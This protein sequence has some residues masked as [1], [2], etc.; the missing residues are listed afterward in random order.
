MSGIYRTMMMKFCEL[1][2][3]IDYRLD[4][5]F[6]LGKKIHYSNDNGSN[7]TEID[8]EETNGSRHAVSYI[9]VVSANAKYFQHRAPSSEQEKSQQRYRTSSVDSTTEA[10][11]GA[12]L[13]RSNDS[14]A[15]RRDAA[16]LRKNKGVYI[17]VV[18]EN[19]V[20]YQGGGMKT[21]EILEAVAAVSK[22]L[23]ASLFQVNEASGV[24]KQVA[25]DRAST[26]YVDGACTWSLRY[27]QTR[28]RD[29]QRGSQLMVRKIGVHGWDGTEAGYGEFESQERLA[30]LFAP[31]GT[32][33][34]IHVRH[35]VENNSIEESAGSDLFPSPKTSSGEGGGGKLVNSSYAI[36]TFA[37]R[38]EAESV[39][40]APYPGVFAGDIRL[41][42]SPFD[43]KKAR[44]ST[45][46]PFPLHFSVQSAIDDRSILR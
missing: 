32:I 23:R 19:V 16:Q 22:E 45:A 28:H 12:E 39:L 14:N 38:A 36:V 42:I 6:I 3:D 15:K 35:R 17:S 46:T 1:D 20:A 34:R 43:R 24:Y 21:T 11:D 10:F 18:D 37:T 9:R 31:F 30:D 33:V 7:R 40:K 27:V 29:H 4:R 41:D 13:T 44:N 8:Y 5:Y 2:P 25:M 26:D